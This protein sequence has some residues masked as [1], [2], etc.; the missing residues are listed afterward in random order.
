MQY[1]ATPLL[2]FGKMLSSKRELLFRQ[3]QRQ[4]SMLKMYFVHAPISWHNRV[5]RG[6][7]GFNA[8][9]DSAGYCYRNAEVLFR[10]PIHFLAA[11][12]KMWLG[13]CRRGELYVTTVVDVLDS[14]ACFQW[15]LE[16]G[17]P[18]GPRDGKSP[19]LMAAALGSIGCVELARKA[20]CPSWGQRVCCQGCRS[21]AVGRVEMV[22]GKRYAL[23]GVALREGA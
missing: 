20:H 16:S 12:C 18:I 3:R 2:A 10:G 21:R 1:N 17:P 4:M 22:F 6:L 7:T 11:E 19:L 9:A 5:R 13:V 15:A 14:P 8:P 23:S